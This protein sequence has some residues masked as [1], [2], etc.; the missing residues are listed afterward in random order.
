MGFNQTY[1]IKT[2]F[3]YNTKKILLLFDF[4]VINNMVGLVV[5]VAQFI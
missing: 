2:Q 5:V 3:Q 1:A 4:T